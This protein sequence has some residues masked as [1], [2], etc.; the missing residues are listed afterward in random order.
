MASCITSRIRL[1]R[2]LAK[3]LYGAEIRLIGRKS[4][5][6]DAPFFFGTKVKKVAFKPFGIFQLEWNSL[7]KEYKSSLIVSQHS[8]KKFMG[9]HPGRGLFLSE[10]REWP[11]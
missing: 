3:I 7:K 1:E 10:G 8:W 9:S 11:F 5:I 4:E 6:A 2:A